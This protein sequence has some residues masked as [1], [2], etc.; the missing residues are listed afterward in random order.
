MKMLVSKGRMLDLKTIEVASKPCV[1][2]RHKKL[3]FEKIGNPPK[4]EKL[5]VVHSYFYV[6]TS[7]S[8]V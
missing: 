5:E 1:L 8:L 2:G 3:T 4:S 6:L 7:V